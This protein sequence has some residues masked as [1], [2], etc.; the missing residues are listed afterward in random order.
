M[1]PVAAKESTTRYCEVKHVDTLWKQQLQS[2]Q[3]ICGLPWRRHSCELGVGLL[4]RT[5]LYSTFCGTADDL[6]TGEG[7]CCGVGRH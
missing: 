4:I 5:E 2:S 7:L 1:N 3:G 6:L